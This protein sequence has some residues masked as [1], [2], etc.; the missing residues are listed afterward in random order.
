MVFLSLPNLPLPVPGVRFLYFE[1]GTVVKKEKFCPA[2]SSR[3]GE[4]VG[5]SEPCTSQEAIGAAFSIADVSGVKT[6]GEEE[7]NKRLER[8]K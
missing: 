8:V 1:W 6:G 5:K 4:E 2:S 3:G 7:R